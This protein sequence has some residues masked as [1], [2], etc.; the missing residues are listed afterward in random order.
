MNEIELFGWLLR[1]E[2]MHSK[3]PEIG[4]PP[5]NHIHPPEQFNEDQANVT[6]ED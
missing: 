3:K 6:F 4:Q 5:S 2:Y 1:V